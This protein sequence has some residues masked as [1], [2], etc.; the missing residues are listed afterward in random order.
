MK[1][2][3]DLII[4]K[5]LNNQSTSEENQKLLN[6]IEESPQNKSY[7]LSIQKLYVAGKVNRKLNASEEAE[8]RQILDTILG[9]EARVKIKHIQKRKRN[10]FTYITSAAAVALL[11]L[12][13]GIYD[14]FNDKPTQF[15]DKD[16][17]VAVIKSQSPTLVLSDGREV[18]LSGLKANIEDGGV[19]I[20]NEES[21]GLS[22]SGAKEGT[23]VK[24]NTLKIP[25]ASTFQITLSDGTKIWLNAESELRYP[26]TFNGK[27]RRVY[28]KGEA[29]FEVAKQKD[30]TPFIVET[31]KLTTKVLGTH[32]NVS[33]YDDDA[34]HHVTLSEGSVQVGVNT[35][36]VLL[37]VGDQI[38]YNQSNQSI[39]T[40]QVDVSE[41]N[42]WIDG[43]TWFHNIPLN[44]LTTMIKRFYGLKLVLQDETLSSLRFSGKLLKSYDPKEI[45]ELIT[46]SA[47]LEWNI[48]DDAIVLSK[49]N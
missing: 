29:Y 16:I 31:K 17:K 46:E 23:E 7:F 2:E 47:G 9:E 34:S 15:A 39:V 18:A 44:E 35:Q 30:K 22:Y 20:E 38:R 36:Q 1:I 32:F 19:K 33:C 4:V 6:W 45:I 28:L 26:V 40:Q 12:T 24:Y 42:S 21:S 48:I 11:M 13:L 14:Y 27:E 3:M 25:I 41:Y 49:K 43:Q 5:F 8:A 37:A 10:I